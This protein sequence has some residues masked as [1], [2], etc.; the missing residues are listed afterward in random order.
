M[1]PFMKK[2]YFRLNWPFHLFLFLFTFFSTAVAGVFWLNQDP[3]DLSNFKLGI[4]YAVAILFILSCHEFGHFF[5][6]R[7]HKVEATLPYYIPFPPIPSL[8]QLFL[9]FGTFGA[10][11][12]TKTVVPDKKAMFDIGV[13]GPI[14]GFIAS[15]I[16]LIFG[17]LTLPGPEFILHIHPDYNFVLNAAPHTNGM[18]L[19]FGSTILYSFF[20]SVLTHPA[21]QFVPPMSEIYHY[22]FLCVGWF[23]LFVTAM[24]LIP[25]GQFDGGHVMYAM[26]GGMHKIISRVSCILLLAVGFPS[27]LDAVLRSVLGAIKGHEF[28]Q[29]VPFAQYS[30]S[31]WMVWALIALFVVK[32]DHPPV[33][34]DAP[35]GKKRMLVGVAAAAIFIVSF[36]LNPITL[37]P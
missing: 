4:P 6:A 13:A 20:G 14:A 7:H 5:A 29:I 33:A 32:L 22:P 24:N 26:F 10:V 27:F 25:I 35:I 36:S 9:N 15:C 19:T 30:W 16:V 17:F 31:A 12:R 37:T 18:S 28:G 3:F 8:F 11:I 23:G 34:D 1:H 21:S 2:S